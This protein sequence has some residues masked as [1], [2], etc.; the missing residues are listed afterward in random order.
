[1]RA[2][3]VLLLLVLILSQDLAMAQTE[4]I[5]DK[6]NFTLA[7]DYEMT[8]FAIAPL[9]WSASSNETVKVNVTLIKL[10]NEISS[11]E[12]QI[13]TIRKFI[14]QNNE[15]TG[16]QEDFSSIVPQ[17][18]IDTV[19]DELQFEKSV[20][21]PILGDLFYLNITI[22]AITKGNTT[23]VDA[24]SYSFRFPEG[25]TI[26]VNREDNL[27]PLINLYGFPPASFF[28]NWIPLYIVIIIF[29]LSPA[30]ISGFYK[31]KDLEKKRGEAQNE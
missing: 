18:E 4:F 16:T 27:V 26:L 6:H 21:T 1:M 2:K 15:D 13:I 5:G 20:N 29:V 19:G 14:V 30:Y 3:V 7:P 25:N 9:T 10:P 23:Q 31:V 11:I 22:Y 24:K 28:Q 17:R 8:A 12:I